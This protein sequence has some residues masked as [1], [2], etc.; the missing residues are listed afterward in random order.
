MF[1][2]GVNGLDLTSNSKYFDFALSQQISVN[3]LVS[4]VSYPLTPCSRESWVGAGKSILEI[5]DRM[6][7]SSYLCPPINQEFSITGMLTSQTYKY[8][9]ISVT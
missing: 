7:F 3:G 8:I 5:Y 6:N 2:I 9:K 4:N 1:A